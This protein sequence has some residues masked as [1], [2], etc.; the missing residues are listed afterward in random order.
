MKNVTKILWYFNFYCFI[1][2]FLSTFIGCRL[3]TDE[4]KSPIETS[5]SVIISK[6]DLHDMPN[7]A[8]KTLEK[9][10]AW[11]LWKLDTQI[12]KESLDAGVNPYAL[13]QVVN[14]S[15]VISDQ[16]QL[17]PY[18]LIIEGYLART[19]LE[20]NIDNII[21]ALNRLYECIEL[22]VQ[23]QVSVDQGVLTIGSHATMRKFAQESLD[24]LEVEKSSQVGLDAEGKF[25]LTIWQKIQALIDTYQPK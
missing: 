10:F 16:K 5:E 11:G 21:N 18:A 23:K 3:S 15:H 22:L 6:L 8:P 2:I 7:S 13:D 12:I 9:R 1:F 14:V 17:S 24:R 19:R 4:T 20:E 25:A